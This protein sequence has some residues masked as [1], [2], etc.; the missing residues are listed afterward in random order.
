MGRGKQRPYSCSWF[1]RLTMSGLGLT[2]SGLGLTMSGLGLTMSG[3]C[4]TLS[5]PLG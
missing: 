3:S 2:M 5:V 1:D 4:L